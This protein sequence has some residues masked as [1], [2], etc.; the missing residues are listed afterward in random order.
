MAREYEFNR[1]GVDLR[2]DVQIADGLF[3]YKDTSL[4]ENDATVDNAFLRPQDFIKTKCIM[5]N[6]KYADE[7]KS[8]I[9]DSIKESEELQ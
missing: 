8:C 1:M 7:L 3:A 5:L 9:D 2:N 6:S 4:I